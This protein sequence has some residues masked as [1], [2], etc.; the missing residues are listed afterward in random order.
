MISFFCIAVF[1]LVIL[2]RQILIKKNNFVIPVFIPH[3]GCPHQCVF[4]N[5]NKITGVEKQ[6][7]VEEVENKIVN[8]LRTIGKRGKNVLVAFYG[9]S[10][11]ALKT[12]LQVSYLRA[13]LKY[14][15]AG[16]ID[17]IRIST[18]PD[19]IDDDILDVLSKYGVSQIELGIQ[20]FDDAV[21]E[22]SS[23]GCNSGHGKSASKLIRERGFLLGHQLMVGL[24]GDSFKKLI[25]TAVTSIRYKP[26][27]VR[28]YPTLVMK[29]TELAELKNY[30]PLSL[31]EAVE[32]TRFLM[33]FYQEH[34]V[35]ILRVGLHPP[36]DM[37]SILSGP[38]HPSF[39]FLVNTKIW[40]AFLSKIIRSSR[41]FEKLYLSSDDYQ[42]AIGY[43]RKN[44]KI[45]GEQVKLLPKDWIARNCVCLDSGQV[46]NRVDWRR[47][48]LQNLMGKYGY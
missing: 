7:T 8:Y 28:V 3:S 47:E 36:S 42:F 1:S 45:L 17:G 10:F 26:D 37:T 24:P 20:S 46:F 40:G 25:E 32:Q 6:P 19:Y 22:L 38:F 30:K 34:L 2:T 23:R 35:R 13:A 44:R 14:L 31:N 43:K 21:L 9:G 5:Q 18:R 41:S 48:Y 39:R 33:E 16:R 27:M 15:R 4:C 12:D 11:T 29:G